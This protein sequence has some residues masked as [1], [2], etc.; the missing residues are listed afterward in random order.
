VVGISGDC[1]D[2]VGSVSARNMVL[3]THGVPERLPDLGGKAW[4]TPMAINGRG[5]VV[6]FANSPDAADPLDFDVRA[7]RWT[8]GRGTEPLGTLHDGETSQALGVNEA[9]Q[10]VGTSCGA[11]CR[12]FLHEHGQLRDLNDLVAP[13]EGEWLRFAGDI[14]NFGII[15]G[16]YQT[17]AGLRGAFVA[18]PTFFR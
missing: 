18:I 17:T 5:V 7:F 12:A 9:G 6:G 15:V 13:V 4:N 14:N 1:G 8:R 11:T 3:W 2:A 16:Q 10:I